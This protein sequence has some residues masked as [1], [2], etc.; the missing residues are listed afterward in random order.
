MLLINPPDHPRLSKLDEGALDEWNVAI[1]RCARLRTDIL[2][3]RHL[4]DLDVD[5]IEAWEQAG[6]VDPLPFGH[7]RFRD[8]GRVWDYE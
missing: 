5:A 6:I 3:P 7:R 8:R 2:G 4:S 1:G